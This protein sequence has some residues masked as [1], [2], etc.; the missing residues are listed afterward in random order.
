VKR[1]EHSTIKLIGIAPR[2][3]G[4]HDSFCAY[5]AA[6]ALLCALRPEFSDAFEADKVR[7]DPLFSGV[8][9]RRRETIDMLVSDWLASGIELRRVT[10]ALNHACR[11]SGKTVFKHRLVARKNSNFVELCRKIDDGLPSLLAWEGR[12]IGN[13]TVVVI[14]YERH[15]RSKSR[16]LRVI[17][18]IQ[19]QEVLEWGQLEALAQGP[20]EIVT[21]TRHDGFR[22]D[23]LT[24]FRDTR[25]KLIVERTL[26]E[27]YD[28]R[29]HVYETI[30][31]RA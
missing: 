15:A 22:P 2:V 3:Q 13:H 9:R 18:P 14:G 10:G 19:M 6:A 23:K 1:A 26:H 28:P 11:A 27:R 12:E 24:T 5:Y 21:C 30:L 7:A 20:L 8:R 4:S 29:R 31:G 17:D 16:W 25:Q